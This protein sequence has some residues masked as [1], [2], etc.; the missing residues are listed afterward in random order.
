MGKLKMI[1]LYI[2]LW[3]CWWKKPIWLCFCFDHQLDRFIPNRSTIDEG[4]SCFF[5]RLLNMMWV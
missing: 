3:I 1:N 2:S 5:L 4:L